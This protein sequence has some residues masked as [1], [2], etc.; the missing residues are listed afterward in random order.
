M[1]LTGNNYK[2][3]IFSTKKSSFMSDLVTVKNLELYNHGKSSQ[4]VI[5]IDSLWQF[6]NFYGW[7]FKR[8]LN[9]K[10]TNAQSAIFFFSI[11]TYRVNNSVK[12]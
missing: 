9:K 4:S 10:K 1:G 3:L 6:N 7:R 12:Y 11:L 2:K 8:N 5:Q